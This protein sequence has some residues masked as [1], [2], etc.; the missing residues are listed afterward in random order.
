MPLSDVAVRNAK[1]RSKAYKLADSAGLFL[2]VTP[3]G[4]RLWRMKYRYAGKEKLLSFGPY[5]IV[6]LSAARERRDDAKRL[7]NAG[8]DP[9]VERKAREE[10]TRK[11]SL[12]TFG[13]L[14]EEFI[15]REGQQGKAANTVSKLRWLLIELAE[16]LYDRP[17]RDITPPEALEVLRSI[18]VRGLRESARRCRSSMSRV[19]RYAIMTGRAA[20]DPTS[21]LQGALLAPAVKHH[22]AL[23]EPKTV[24]DLLNAIDALEGSLIVRSA[25]QLLAV[26]YPRPGELRHA[27]W[28]EIDWERRVWAIPAHRTKM[29]RA[30][31]IPLPHQAVR[32]LERVQ[33]VTRRYELIFPGTRS[34]SRPLSENTL[35]VA[36]RRLGYSAGE[37]TTHGFRT[38][39][40]TLLNESGLWNPDAIERSLAHVDRNTVRQA[41]ARGSYWDE[42]VKMAQWWADYLDDLRNASGKR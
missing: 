1:A 22:A 15:T 29:R 20:A 41:Y 39:A 4:S 21:A 35:N 30:H 42:R 27:Q 9:G 14:A 34:P 16:P 19:F 13:L 23:I 36:L 32:I 6:S 7:L 37:M 17:I 28:S 10:A 18:E 3:S 24:G 38:T 26:C 31:L 40:S 11:Q 8:L 25:L 5:P 2:Q 12:E 33:Q